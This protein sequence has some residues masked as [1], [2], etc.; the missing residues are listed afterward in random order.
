MRKWF[1]NFKK[2]NFNSLDE[3]RSGGPSTIDDDELKIKIAE[4]PRINV[5]DLA[6]LLKISKSAV[7]EHL[8]K[9]GF[10]SRLDVWVPHKL[11]EKVLSDRVF[12][13]FRSSK[14]SP[15]LKWLIT[16]DEKW[17]MYDN[18]QRKRSWGKLEVS[19]S[20]QLNRICTQKRFY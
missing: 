11:T 1:A 17:I 4:N 2:G 13:A 18:V 10:V 16:G 7:H 20:H 12:P 6:E 8:Q 3:E 9:L 5:R 19:L 15:V 14:E